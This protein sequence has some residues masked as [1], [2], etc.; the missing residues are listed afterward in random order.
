MA[1]IIF[2]IIILTEISI[3]LKSYHIHKFGLVFLLQCHW[4]T[5]LVDRRFSKSTEA[6]ADN[7]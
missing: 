6:G 1:K 2:T 3:Q 4:C 5:N 7:C